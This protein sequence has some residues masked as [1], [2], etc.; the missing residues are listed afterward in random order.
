VVARFWECFV[1]TFTNR[2]TNAVICEF[3]VPTVRQAL[4][5]AA[6]DKAVLRGADLRGAYLRGAYLSGADLREADLSGADLSGADLRG[7][8][9]SGA[10]LRG[11]VLSGADLREADLSGAYLRG[12]DLRGADL[13]DAVLRGEK[14]TKTPLFISN[15]TWPVT[16]T[17]IN[18]TIGC[19][20]HTHTEWEQFSDELISRM[21]GRALAFWKQWKTPL[22]AMC[23]EFSAEVA[24]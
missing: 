5:R 15:L 18:L 2:F 16:I 10:V 22:M 23:K 9:L 20:H 14:L 12:A 11:A 13:S 3:D 21:D 7:A 17:T 19:Q 6:K 1:I 24:K 8:D 4:E